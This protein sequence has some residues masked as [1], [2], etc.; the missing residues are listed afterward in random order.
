MPA[1]KGIN[2]LLID[3]II[4]GTVVANSKTVSWDVNGEPA[5]VTNKDSSQMT[6]LLDAGVASLTF[7]IEGIYADTVEQ[8]ALH[9]RCAAI[10]KNTYTIVWG[11]KA[12]TLDSISG[13]FIVK[14]YSTAGPYNEGQTFSATLMSAG[15]F[16]YAAGVA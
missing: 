15:P 4:T 16:T 10:T 5:D 14:D 1:Q 7:S 12:T 6:E 9:T 11:D 3:G 13:E 8:N 2:V